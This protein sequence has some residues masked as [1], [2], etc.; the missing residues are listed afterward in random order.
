MTA[1]AQDRLD[2]G[3]ISVERVIDLDNVPFSIFDI[4]PD[5]TADSIPPLQQRLLPDVFAP[6]SAG[7]CQTNRVQRDDFWMAKPI[8]LPADA[9]PPERALVSL[10][11]V[12]CRQVA[13]QVEVI[14]D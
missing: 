2:L 6:A 7:H 1:A 8:K 12:A 9:I 14:V 3:D 4:Y 5:A 11:F 13:L 10:E